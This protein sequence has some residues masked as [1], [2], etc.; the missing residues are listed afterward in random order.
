[1]KNIAQIKKKIK[2]NSY[3]QYL[4]CRFNKE[5]LKAEI[6]FKRFKHRNKSHIEDQNRIARMVNEMLTKGLRITLKTVSEYT[7]VCKETLRNWGCNS[8]IADFKK[9]Q[10]SGYNY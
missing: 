3:D 6:M 9:L 5:V 1:M 2:W 10:N 4:S 8:I 7:G